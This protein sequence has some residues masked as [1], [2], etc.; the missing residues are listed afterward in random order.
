[1]IGLIHKLSKTVL[2]KLSHNIKMK[3]C[4]YEVG[5]RKRNDYYLFFFF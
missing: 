3:I 1:M 2:K 4:I 5:T